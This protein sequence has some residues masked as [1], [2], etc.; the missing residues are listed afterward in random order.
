MPRARRPESVRLSRDDWDDM[1]TYL[2]YANSNHVSAITWDVHWTPTHGE[3][4]SYSKRTFH[5]GVRYANG[6]YSSCILVDTVSWDE[7]PVEG[8][9]HHWG[10]TPPNLGEIVEH[11]RT[12]YKVQPASSNLRY[13]PRQNDDNNGG[14]GAS[15]GG[16][17]KEV[18]KD[19]YGGYFY[20]GEDEEYH[21]CDS[22]GNEIQTTDRKTGYRT[23]N[24]RGIVVVFADSRNQTYYYSHGKPK[25]CSLKED[26]RSGTYY[27]VDDMGRER[28]AQ[29]AGTKPRWMGGYSASR[30]SYGQSSASRS[31]YAQPSAYSSYG[32]HSS[33]D[34]SSKT[35]RVQYLTDPKSGRKY[36]VGADGQAHWA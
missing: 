32:S 22:E 27:F 1:L 18:K 24:P 34:S 30:S 7:V 26:P 16:W 29:Y 13:Q 5:I 14:A 25:S 15:G 20:I 12:L 3:T 10:T 2:E 11:Y 31:S 17:K 33:Y 36:Y 21:A 4:R 28:D 35:S 8:T 23:S 6:R 19:D 9:I